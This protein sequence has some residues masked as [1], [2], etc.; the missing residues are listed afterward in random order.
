MLWYE[1]LRKE[2][3]KG[4]QLKQAGSEYGKLLMS[5]LVE[6][7][8]LRF[9]NLLLDIVPRVEEINMPPILALQCVVARAHRALPLIG[10]QLFTRVR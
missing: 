4:S 1:V 10:E 5:C 2:V 7:I 6:R 9:E 3:C 8:I